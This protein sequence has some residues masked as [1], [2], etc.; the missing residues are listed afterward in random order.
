MYSKIL[1]ALDGSEISKLAFSRALD[2]AKSDNAELHA[3]YVIESGIASPG[4]VDTTWEL[5]YQRF[6]NEGRAL[7][8]E[9]NVAADAAGVKVIPHVETGHAGDTIVKTAKDI[10]CDL[11]VVGSL[12][13]SKLDRLLLGS[14]SA[15]VVNYGKTNILIVRK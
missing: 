8:E 2:L 12:G 14:V 10:D 15:H 6:E 13:K 7:M 11:I 4:P 1:V 3:V 9:L 5:I